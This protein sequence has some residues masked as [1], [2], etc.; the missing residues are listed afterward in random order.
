[1]THPLDA[2]D[3]ALGAVIDRSEDRDDADEPI[4]WPIE[5]GLELD[6]AS[7]AT[8]K[9]IVFDMSEAALFFAHEAWF[10]KELGKNPDM[11]CKQK[12][13]A[14]YRDGVLC[15]LGLTMYVIIPS[16]LGQRRI[17]GVDVSPGAKTFIEFDYEPR[18]SATW[19]RGPLLLRELRCKGHR[20][21]FDP[22]PTE[23]L[24]ALTRPIGFPFPVLDRLEID[25]GGDYAIPFTRAMGDGSEHRAGHSFSPS[26]IVTLDPKA[27]F[28]I[29]AVLDRNHGRR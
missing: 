4:D 22:M 23:G 10:G 8:S 6:L 3:Q 12:V 24:Q 28:E 17:Y 29:P 9:L 5:Y 20:I 14:R 7:G 11:I 19:E 18:F 26:S 27:R 2:A 15:E 21:R 13:T 25:V 1:M 16:R